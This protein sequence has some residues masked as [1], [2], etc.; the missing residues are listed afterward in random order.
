MR[1]DRSAVLTRE[2]IVTGHT[3][4]PLD[5]LAALGADTSAPGAAIINRAPIPG[6]GNRDSAPARIAQSMPAQRGT[7]TAP[8]SRP[9]TAARPASRPVAHPT[10]P[11]ASAAAP[12]L[13]ILPRGTAPCVVPPR[14]PR[15]SRAFYPATAARPPRC[16]LTR[17]AR[18]FAPC[19]A[20][21]PRASCPTRPTCC[22]LTRV[23]CFLAP[24][25]SVARPMRVPCLPR[26]ARSHRRSPARPPVRP[27]PSR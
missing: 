16:L 27:A 13:P 17:A 12:P 7:P 6:P 5:L 1:E 26:T 18:S 4:G 3:A 9:V 8:G 22:L 20:R 24:A 21:P 2:L 23:A 15:P 11:H 14:V 25:L 10:G 19:A